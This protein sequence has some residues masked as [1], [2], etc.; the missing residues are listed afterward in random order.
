MS[1]LLHFASRIEAAVASYVSVKG[2]TDMEKWR[3]QFDQEK[4]SIYFC[5]FMAFSS[6]FAL[7]RD[8]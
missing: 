3:H 2:A 4:V 6:P 5:T 1:S 7:E 8:E